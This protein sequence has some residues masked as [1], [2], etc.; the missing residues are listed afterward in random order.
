MAMHRLAPLVWRQAEIR[1]FQ[2]QRR[3]I[4]RHPGQSRVLDGSG[5]AVTFAS[6]SRGRGERIQAR[7]A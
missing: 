4:G 3:A 2:G 5:L 6:R 7:G 1:K